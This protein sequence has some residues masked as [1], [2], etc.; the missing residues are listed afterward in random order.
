MRIII[1]DLV[2]TLDY[3]NKI[4][5]FNM[6]FDLEDF[7]IEIL[8][9]DVH[10]F[11]LFTSLCEENGISYDNHEIEEDATK[12]GSYKLTR[13]IKS[14]VYR[15]IISGQKNEPEFPRIIELLLKIFNRYGA[16]DGVHTDDTQK[17][18]IKKAGYK[19]FNFISQS[20]FHYEENISVCEIERMLSIK[21]CGQF[22]DSI[23]LID[24]IVKEMNANKPG[25]GKKWGID[26]Q[27]LIDHMNEIKKF[28]TF[29]KEL[30]D[31]H[32]DATKLPDNKMKRLR[33][34]WKDGHKYKGYYREDRND[35]VHLLDKELLA[36][37]G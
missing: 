28:V 5:F 6:L 13:S 15:D 32:P 27:K 33:E 31:A 26:W 16:V 8:T 12:K 36:I 11:E 10:V 14:K 21:M 29:E 35:V 25:K 19:Y 9:H 23:C 2:E 18:P 37:A 1:D 22:V 30:I 7:E 20:V 3:K 4:S 17:E 24:E 34:I